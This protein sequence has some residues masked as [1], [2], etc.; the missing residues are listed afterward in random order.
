MTLE[1]AHAIRFD[2]V[3][4]HL[5]QASDGLHMAGK[6]AKT[7]DPKLVANWIETVRRELVKAELVLNTPAE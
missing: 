7:L 1:T 5:R 4:Y 6:A 2:V 3:G